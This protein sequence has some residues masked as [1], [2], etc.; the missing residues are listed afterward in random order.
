MK[1]RL[2]A[3]GITQVFICGTQY[4]NCICVTAFDAV[5]R[6]FLTTVILDAT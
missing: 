2:R 5:A 6:D 4:P 3:L 1:E